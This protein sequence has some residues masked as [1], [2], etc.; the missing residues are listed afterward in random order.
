MLEVVIA[1]HVNTVF[2]HVVA[3]V[4][5]AI[6]V[7]ISHL[8]ASLHQLIVFVVAHGQNGI[9]GTRD[10]EIDALGETDPLVVEMVFDAHTHR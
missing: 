6:H 10:K 9:K 8:D 3:V 2:L 7:L 5:E 1:L 4:A